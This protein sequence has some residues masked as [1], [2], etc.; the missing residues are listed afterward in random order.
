[1]SRIVS[2]EGEIWKD[3]V[4]YEGLYQI[5]NTG[6]VKSLAKWIYYSNGRK[7][8]LKERILKQKISYGYPRVGL[9]KNKQ[10]KNFLVHRLV[11]TAFRGKSKLCIDHI[12]SDRTD[13]RLG[14][15]SGS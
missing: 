4:G 7:D 1:M 13:N 3:I 10:Q 8:F 12:N 9:T 2:L 6:R 11:M 5:S 15:Y 14:N